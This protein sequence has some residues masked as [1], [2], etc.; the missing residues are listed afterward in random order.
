MAMDYEKLQKK[1][2]VYRETESRL[3][4]FGMNVICLDREME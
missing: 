1:K 3:W 2:A 4:E